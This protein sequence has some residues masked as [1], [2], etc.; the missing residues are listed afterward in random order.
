MQYVPKTN[1]PNIRM[2]NSLPGSLMDETLPG[3]YVPQDLVGSLKGI[4]DNLSMSVRWVQGLPS[5]P[6]LASGQASAVPVGEHV[7]WGSGAPP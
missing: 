7:P 3:F 5:S 6:T 2:Q 4:Y 1:R